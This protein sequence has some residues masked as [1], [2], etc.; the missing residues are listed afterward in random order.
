MLNKE[1]QVLYSY[2]FYIRNE[3]EPNLLGIFLNVYIREC[4]NSVSEVNF[5]LNQ[6]CSQKHRIHKKVSYWWHEEM[7]QT[8]ILLLY[9]T[10]FCMKIVSGF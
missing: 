8:V 5:F 7:N 9:D 2:Q 10:V 3:V 1:K 4:F 6:L